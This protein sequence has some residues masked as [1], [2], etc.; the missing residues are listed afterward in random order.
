MNKIKLM[1]TLPWTYPKN[2]KDN[3]KGFFKSIRNF[4]YRGRY[5][6]APDWDCWDMDSYIL[7]VFK[8]GL[9]VFRKNTWGY[10]ANL[11]F[12]EWQNVLARMEELIDI[13]QTDSIECEKAEVLWD[14]QDELPSKEFNDSLWEVIKEWEEYRQECMDELCDLMKEYFHHLWW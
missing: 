3:I 12:E 4:Y 2:I 8:N 9:E 7:D 11:T 6:I 13:I 5:G 10:P 1:Q 14:K